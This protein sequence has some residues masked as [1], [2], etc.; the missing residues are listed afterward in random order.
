MAARFDDRLETSNTAIRTVPGGV[1]RVLGTLKVMLKIDGTSKALPMKA[2]PN[3]DQDIILG[4]DFCKLFDVDARLGRQRWRVEEGKWRPFV[5]DGDNKKSVVFD[6]C[7]GIS[8]LKETEREMLERLMEHLLV[9]PEGERE[10]GLT[11]LTEH[12]ITLLNPAPIKHHL[13]RMSPKI[14]QIAIE[15]VERMFE[16]GIIERSASDYS[17]APVMIRKSD[18]TYRFC[19]DYRDLNKVTRKD[20]YPIPSMDS[21]LDK[22]RRARYLTKID[23]KQA[24]YQIPMKRPAANILRFCGA[25]VGLV[26]IS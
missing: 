2:V 15:E 9:H 4:M 24:Y 16:E 22:L 5:K 18:G 17:S 1:T 21:I 8:E 11:T 7:A 20:A 26:A 19:V 13:R 14:Q 23:L 3:L 10:L 6:E 12:S 25:G